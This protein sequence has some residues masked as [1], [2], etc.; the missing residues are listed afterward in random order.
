MPYELPAAPPAAADE[1][2]TLEAFLDYFRAVALRKLDGLSREQAVTRPT[3][4]DLTILGTVKHLAHVERNWYQDRFAG[5]DLDFPWSGGDRDADKRPESDDTVEHV[6]AF[7]ERACADS[8]MV[9]RAATSLEQ[10][11]VRTD[12]SLRWI[13][14]HMIEET[15]RHCGHLDI[16]RETI[17][18]KTGN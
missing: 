2:T 7:Y 8:R 16:F 1:R 18:G 12:R 17:D 11:G 4:S 5:R 10:I 9:V 3:A 13:L 15:A 14:V 6:L